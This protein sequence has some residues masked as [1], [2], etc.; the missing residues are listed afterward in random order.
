MT[1]ECL[2]EGPRAT[3]SHLVLAA[4]EQMCFLVMGIIIPL[5]DGTRHTWS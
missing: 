2:L 3:P 5:N 4:S 1:V